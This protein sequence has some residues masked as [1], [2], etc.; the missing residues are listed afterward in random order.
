MTGEQFEHHVV[1]DRTRPMDFEVY[2]I[3]GVTGY[4]AGGGAE[5]PFQP[6]YRVR[7]MGIHDSGDGA[8]YQVRREKRL[9]HRDKPNAACARITLAARRSSLWSIH[10]TRHTRANSINLG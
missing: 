6:F 9:L 4:R 10:P 1:V 8:F 2:Q 7:D 3:Q 5:L